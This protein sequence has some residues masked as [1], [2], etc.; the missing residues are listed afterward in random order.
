MRNKNRS[1][2][3]LKVNHKENKRTEHW[4]GVGKYQ[5]S[6]ICVIDAL[7]GQIGT[8]DILEKHSVRTFP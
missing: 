6:N 3:M 4:R 7:V 1:M 5:H 8:E 2:K